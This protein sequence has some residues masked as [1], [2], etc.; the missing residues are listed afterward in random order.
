MTAQQI[1]A[2]ACAGERSVWRWI[3]RPRLRSRKLIKRFCQSARLRV[4]IEHLIDRLGHESRKCCLGFSGVFKFQISRFSSK[5]L[6]LAR[7]GRR[8]KNRRKKYVELKSFQLKGQRF[9]LGL[10]LRG[11]YKGLLRSIRHTSC[12]FCQTGSDNKQLINRC[13]SQP[14]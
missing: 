10:C 8:K 12:L 6:F 5:M 4:L 3:L 7:W 1:Y 11:G 14:L 2:A 9:D 13:N